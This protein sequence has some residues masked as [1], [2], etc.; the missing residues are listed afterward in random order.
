[1]N[2]LVAPAVIVALGMIGVVALSQQ[3]PPPASG[4]Q[5]K[6]YFQ[7]PLEK[8]PS[9]V[10]RLQICGHSS[11]GRQPVSSPPRRSVVGRPG[12]RSYLYDQGSTTASYAGRRVRL[13]PSRH[14]SPQPKH[15]EAFRAR[16]RAQHNG[17][18]QAPDGTGAL[19]EHQWVGN[20]CR[21]V[22]RTISVPVIVHH[23]RS[24]GQ[25]WSISSTPA[26]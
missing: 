19:A 13:C 21:I 16:D 12:G 20:P 4:F 11:W 14:D 9:R 3:A 25:H 10:V 1:M 24:D 26:C 2:R 5:A 18:G 17:Q 6:P 15:L 8:D 22:L 23:D 7:M